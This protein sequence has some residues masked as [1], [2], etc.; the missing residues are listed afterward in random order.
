MQILLFVNN[1][2]KKSVNLLSIN[3]KNGGTH[4]LLFV[5]KKSYHLSL[6][7]QIMTPFFS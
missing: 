6:T 3:N 4:I 7:L 2:N 1:K 5:N